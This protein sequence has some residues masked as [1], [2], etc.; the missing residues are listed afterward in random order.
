MIPGVFYSVGWSTPI[1]VIFGFI[2]GISLRIAEKKRFPLTL[3]MIVL[4]WNFA[5]TGILLDFAADTSEVVHR[6]YADSE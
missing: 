6:T 4:A 3:T 1:N 5:L 2:L